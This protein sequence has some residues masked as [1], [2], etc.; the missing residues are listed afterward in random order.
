MKKFWNLILA[1]SVILGTVACTDEGGFIL[2][3]YTDGFSFTA[4]IDHTRADIVDNDGA[5]QTVWSGDDT[6]YVTSDKGNFTFT[7]SVEEPSH[8]V[9]TDTEA[10][11][12]RNA[13]PLYASTIT[14]HREHNCSTSLNLSR[15]ELFIKGMVIHKS[16]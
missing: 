16:T 10:S 13:S 1:I 11:V 12:L 14:A 9:S 8:F 5:W 3:N 2:D 7:N 15:M 6:L 4:V